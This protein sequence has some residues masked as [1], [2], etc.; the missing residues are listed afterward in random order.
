MGVSTGIGVVG[1]SSKEASAMCP[2]PGWKFACQF[3]I[4][5]GVGDSGPPQAVC[6]VELSKCDGFDLQIAAGVVD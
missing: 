1:D 2:T 6:G 4:R 5:L 3:G